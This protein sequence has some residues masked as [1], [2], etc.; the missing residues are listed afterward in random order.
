M[1]S[2]ETLT[3]ETD[4]D[5]ICTLTLNR[6]E[7]HNA[8]NALMISELRTAAADIQ[9]D[10]AIRVVILTGAGKS[11]CAGGDLGWMQEQAEK[12]RAGKIAESS[13]LALM[14]HDLDALRKPLIGRVQGPAYGGG[15]GMMAVCDIVV[16][17]K[18]VRLGLT[19]T[20]LGLIPATIGPYVVRRMGEGA[21][22]QVFMNGSLFSAER[23]QHLGLVSIIC[24]EETLD[25]AVAD[26]ARNF[27]AC[28][29]GAVADAKALC[30]TL[31]RSMTDD[32]LEY[33]AEQLADRWET[34]E[35]QSGIRAFF[36]RTKPA[37]TV[38]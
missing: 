10:E 1:K 2:L 37:W 29:P 6:P 32:P 30:Q 12:D 5:G 13:Q 14:L 31:A 38:D 8:L 3:L 20:R 15:V 27:L 4:R 25:Q 19:E 22:R 24:S 18:Q 33:T 11:F 26:E 35:A 23:A 21:A 7:K 28:A 16:A 36:S 9:A 34:E 17:D